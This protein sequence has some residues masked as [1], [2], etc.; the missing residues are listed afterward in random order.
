MG[1]REV[2]GHIPGPA[3]HPPTACAAHTAPYRTLVLRL[4]GR[5]APAGGNGGRALGHLP[6]GWREPA[7][8][9]TAGAARLRRGVLGEEEASG[10]GEPQSLCT[11]RQAQSPVGTIKPPSA[12]PRLPDELLIQL[13][14]VPH[15]PERH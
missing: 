2:W 7:A 8:G 6:A 1:Y 11:G 3:A 5:R 12:P 14:A 15:L 9:C 13:L 4:E 10:E